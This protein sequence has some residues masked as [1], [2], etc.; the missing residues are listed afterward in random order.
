MER[1]WARREGE[2]GRRNSRRDGKA[3]RGGE[4]IAR[5]YRAE[6]GRNDGGGARWAWAMRRRVRQCGEAVR[7]VGAERRYSPT[8]IQVCGEAGE[9]VRCDGAERQCGMIG[10][11]VGEARWMSKMVGRD[12]Q[13]RCLFELVG[14]NGLARGLWKWVGH[15]SEERCLSAID[16]REGSARRLVYVL[17]DEGGARASRYGVFMDRDRRATGGGKIVKLLLQKSRLWCKMMERLIQLVRRWSETEEQNDG[18]KRRSEKEV[19]DV[20]AKRRS[21]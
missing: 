18:T 6:M 21:W 15:D 16:W 7:R 12:G 9:A 20:G 14:C 10:L 4:R 17:G 2:A 11:Q 13:V 5:P 1:R 19:Q 3:K 8:D